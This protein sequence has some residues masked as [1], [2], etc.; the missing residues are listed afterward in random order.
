MPRNRQLMR[1]V[2]VSR[3]SKKYPAQADS[4]QPRRR[5]FRRFAVPAAAAALLL[6]VTQVVLAVPPTA[7]FTIS[8]TTP[9]RGQSV[10]FRATATDPDMGTITSYAWDFGDGTTG[11]GQEVSH[12][13][14]TLGPKTVRLTVTDSAGETFVV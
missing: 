2:H 3:R 14:D 9:T 12:P 1:L 6:I 8:D 7:D 13:Y 4:P 5:A 11:T 10:D